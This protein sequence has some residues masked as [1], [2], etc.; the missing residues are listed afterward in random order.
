MSDIYY[1][2]RRLKSKNIENKENVIELHNDSMK[3]TEKIKDALDLFKQQVKG[4][5]VAIICTDDNINL[6]DLYEL[7]DH[8]NKIDITSSSEKYFWD[9]GNYIHC[10]ELSSYLEVL[11]TITI[12]MRNLGKK[13]D[14]KYIEK[15]IEKCEEDTLNERGFS[16]KDCFSVYNVDSITNEILPRNELGGNCADIKFIFILKESEFEFFENSFNIPGSIT[17]TNYYFP[18]FLEYIIRSRS[19]FKIQLEIQQVQSEKEKKEIIKLFKDIASSYKD[20]VEAVVE[21]LDEIFSI[22]T[23]KQE[24]NI[25]DNFIEVKNELST[26]ITKLS[27]LRELDTISESEITQLR[28]VIEQLSNK[29]N[30]YVNS[31]NNYIKEISGLSHSKVINKS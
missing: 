3:K 15:F 21:A 19:D 2:D 30:E 20:V 27:Q 8:Y 11:K 14:S 31:I 7:F 26:L 6:K 22:I 25:S 12:Y 10:E 23:K 16:F 18:Y 1:F 28:D 4:I 17:E 24:F 5:H 13:I 29:T 9:N